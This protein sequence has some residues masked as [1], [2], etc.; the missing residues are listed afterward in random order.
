VTHVGYY[1]ETSFD[2]GSTSGLTMQIGDG[3]DGDGHMEA[4]EL[5]EDASEVDYFHN[6]T[7]AYHDGNAV[8]ETT[9]KLYSTADT[10]DILFTGSGANLNTMTSGKVIVY[11]N[12]LRLNP[13]F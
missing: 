3:G 1:L 7:G 11:A 6:N 12:I 13:N 9:G 4:K 5:H 10:L 2:G 8:G